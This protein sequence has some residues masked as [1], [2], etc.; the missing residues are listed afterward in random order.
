SAMSRRKLSLIL[1]ALVSGAASLVPVSR[2]QNP[3]T[4]ISI[5]VNT[6]R[7]PINPEIYGVAFASSTDLADLNAPL[8]RSGGNATT[9][10]NWQLNADNRGSD[11]FF[12]SI[13]Y[14]NTPGE[15][16][17]SFITGSR[18][19]GAEPMLTIPMIGWVA[20]VGTNRSKLSSFSIAKYGAQQSNDWQWFPDAGNGVRTNSQLITGN[21][22]NDANVPA[23][24][25]FQQGWAQH[26]VNRWGTAAAGGLRYYLLDNEP[27]IWHATH[28]DVHPT[29]ANMDEMKTKTI[30]YAGK[31]KA[32][33]PSAIVVGPEEWGWSGY[34]LSGF[35]QQ[36]GSQH[37]WSNLPDRAAHGGADYLPWLLDQIR[38]HDVA[39]GQRLLDVFSVHYYPQGGEFSDDVSTAMQQRRN[40]STRSLWDPNYIDETWINDKVKLVP[41]LKAWVAANYPGTKTGITEYNWG[42]ENHINGATAQADVYGIFGREGLDI[43]ARWTTPAATTPTY[44]AMKM[45]RNYDGSKRGFGETSVTCSAPSPD[46][47]SAFAAVRVDGALTVMVINKVAGNTPVTM[48]LG[49]FASSGTAQVWQLTSSNVITR[50]ADIAYSGGSVSATVPQQSITLF[51]VRGA[52]ACASLG[53]SSQ[54]FACEPGTGGFAV[55]AP[56]GCS[57]AAASNASWISITAGTGTGNGTVAYSITSNAAATPRSGT[58]TVD[59]QTFTVLQG[60]RFSDVP[61]SHQFFQ[62][63]GKLSARGITAGCGSGNYCPDAT[64]TRAQMAIFIEKGMGITSPPAPS[65][66]VFTDVPPNHFAYAFIDDC[67]RRGIITGCSSNTFCPDAIVTRADMAVFVERALG[68]FSPPTPATQRFGDVPPSH[69]AYAFIDDFARRGITAGCGS[70]NYCPASSVT[71]GQMAVFLVRAFNL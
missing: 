41:R 71:R 27:S 22:P 5:N 28:R 9:Q 68:V 44:K 47:L 15:A 34:L 14:T 4:T 64:V 7:H 35:D 24:S 65:A 21:D 2:A 55:T 67:S 10:Y 26:L 3:S 16:G 13:A 53:T 33:D 52:G 19:G 42:A 58:I 59:G 32:V 1:I 39:S 57:W 46:N 61:T 37:G 18:A 49:G 31:I 25:S 29:G 51:V 69:P 60:A 38:Q 43:A 62:F 50:L 48:S 70:G 20:K 12:E 17:D 63:I 11:W 6:G 54:S 56:A 8:N 30:D 40:R 66:Q 36:W 45:Y 23:D